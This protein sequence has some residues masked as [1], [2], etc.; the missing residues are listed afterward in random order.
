MASEQSDDHP[1]CAYPMHI[2]KREPDL[3]DGMPRERQRL[4][5]RACGHEQVRM[6]SAK[7]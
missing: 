2:A 5:C 7:T 6:V 4:A 3:Q 1:R